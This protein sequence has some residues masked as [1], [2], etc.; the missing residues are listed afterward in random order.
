MRHPSH[1]N[2]IDYKSIETASAATVSMEAKTGDEYDA[3]KCE[4]CSGYH[5]GHS[6]KGSFEIIITDD[7][8][9]IFNDQGKEIDIDSLPPEVRNAIT[10][11]T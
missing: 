2:K 8:M 7:E 9:H 5:I 4:L 6:R 1:D 3:Y 11:I 10:R